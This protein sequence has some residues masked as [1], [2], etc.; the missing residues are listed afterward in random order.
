MAEE[1]VEES[2]RAR[3]VSINPTMAE[4]TAEESNRAK[5][6]NSLAAQRDNAKQEQRKNRPDRDTGN[7]N[8]DRD[9]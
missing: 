8:D 4:E 2:N 5:E 7:I 1:T 6:S 9:T 3:N